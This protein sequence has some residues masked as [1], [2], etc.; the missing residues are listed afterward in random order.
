MWY[1][2][3]QK[4]K[5]EIMIKRILT[6]DRNIL[7]LQKFFWF[8]KLVNQN[9]PKCGA[10]SQTECKC[11]AFWFSRWSSFFHIDGNVNFDKKLVSVSV[12][13]KSL[14]P[15]HLTDC[16]QNVGTICT[17]RWMSIQNLKSLGH[18]WIKLSSREVY[19]WMSMINVSISWKS[20]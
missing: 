20:L 10:N 19:I 4:N 14:L 18:R 8:K 1:K 9:S 5:V 7:F 11:F 2:S 13:W 16:P 17:V 15:W 6:V 12:I 3:T